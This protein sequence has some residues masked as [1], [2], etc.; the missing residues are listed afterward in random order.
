MLAR[1][2]AAQ[3]WRLPV[4]RAR[5]IEVAVVGRRPNQ[6]TGVRIL[7]VHEVLPAE[8]R[9][10]RR[11]PVTSPSLTLLDLAGVLNSAELA[12]ALNEARVRRIVTEAHLE[13][14][15][16]AHAL[17]TG[18]KALRR[19]LD[20]EQ[21]AR[22]TR[23]EAERR[24]LQLMRRHGLEPESDVPIGPW[25]ADFLFRAERV[26]VEVDGYRYH[27]TPKRFVDDRRRAADLSARGFVLVSLTWDDLGVDAD[28]AMERIRRTLEVRRAG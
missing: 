11:L 16:A 9:H 6:L 1:R 26:I 4:P 27:S 5:E 15:L 12:S 23:S 20:S 13:A 19:L 17:R 25:R 22:I 28:D 10:V 24:A 3:L 2:S 14:T 8:V 21:G 18:A 7:H